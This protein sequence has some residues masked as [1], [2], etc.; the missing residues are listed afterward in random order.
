M[1]WLA[2]TVADP[3]VDPPDLSEVL[4]D[5]ARAGVIGDET[6]LFA[7]VSADGRAGDVLI[8]NDLVRF[9][10]RGV[11]EGDFYIQQGGG[12]TDADIVTR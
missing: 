12:I 11:R 3:G 10:V 6:V 5:E 8:Y 7:G 1:F 2:C 4:E 9:V